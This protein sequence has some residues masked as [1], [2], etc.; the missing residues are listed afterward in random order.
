MTEDRRQEIKDQIIEQIKT[1]HD[2]EIPIDIYELGLI[3]DIDIKDSG[4]VILTMT[5]T[6]PACPVAESLPMEV[7]EK[8]MVVDGVIDVDLRLV[9]EPAWSKDKMSE[10]ARFALDMF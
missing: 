5:L 2:P 3:Y 1:V 4:E 8:T 9:W 6:S 10:V 7:V